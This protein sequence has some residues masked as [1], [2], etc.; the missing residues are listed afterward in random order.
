M[1]ANELFRRDAIRKCARP[2]GVGIG[3][4]FDTGGDPDPERVAGDGTPNSGLA[5]RALVR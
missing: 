4:D 5:G 2:S 1:Q 3:V